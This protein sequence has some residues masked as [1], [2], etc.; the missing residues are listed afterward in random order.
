MILRSLRIFCRAFL[1]CGLALT[2]A[3]CGSTKKKTADTGAKIEKVKYFH[4]KDLT[5]NV[6]T[7]DPSIPFEREYRLYGAVSVKERNERMGHYY[8]I[9]WKATDRSQPVTVRLEYRQQKSGLTIKTKEETVQAPKKGNVTRFNVVGEE[10]TKDGP[11]NSWR[12]TLVRGK[13]VLSEEKSY[14][15]E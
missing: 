3:S 5:R 12:V 13:E 7:N 15:W 4:L 6:I 2:L 11:V 10:Y 1:V 8:D 14:L 9:L